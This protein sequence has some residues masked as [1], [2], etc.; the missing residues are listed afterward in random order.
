MDRQRGY[1]AKW[2]VRQRKKIWYDITYMFNLKKSKTKQKQTQIQRLNQRLP[3]KKSGSG[4][5]IG[6]GVK[7][8]KPLAIR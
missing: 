1:Y 6:K 5:K 3:E 2:N 8:Y 7:R 4:G